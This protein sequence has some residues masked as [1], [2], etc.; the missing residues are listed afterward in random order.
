MSILIEDDEVEALLTQLAAASGKEPP[1]VIRD[2]LRNAAGGLR[3]R[4]P[5]EERRR[6]LDEITRRYGSRLIGTPATPDEII[7]YDEHGLP[8]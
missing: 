5:L 3:R 2:L 7:G 4:R 8:T 1:E 6:L